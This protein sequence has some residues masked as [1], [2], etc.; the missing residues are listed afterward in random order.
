MLLIDEVSRAALDGSRPADKVIAWAWYDGAL[1]WDEPLS[2]NSWSR[3]DTGDGKQ[4]VQ[5]QFQLTIADPDGSLSPWLFHDPLG[6]GGTILQIIYQ[7]G[8]AESLNIGWFR[9][10][11]NTPEQSHVHYTI[12]E[13]GYVE[14]DSVHAPHERSVMVP[15]GGTVQ[16]TAVDI[17]A[18]VD[19]DKLLTPES[20]KTTTVL[21]EVS[22][23]I[24]DHFP[25]V[26]EDGVVDGPVAKTLVYERERLEA[27][28]D[29]LA[30]VNARYRMGGDGEMR[31]YPID[32]GPVVWRVEPRAGLVKVGRGQSIAGLYNMWVVT[33]KED[34]TGR[35][36]S[37]ISTIKSGPLRVDG[38]HGRVPN[39]FESEQITSVAAAQKYA[40]TLRDRQNQTY[41]VE[42]SVDTIPRPELQA[43]DRIEVGCPVKDGHVIYIP[44]EVTSIQASGSPVPGPMSLKVSC[45][46]QD[47]FDALARTDWSQYLTREKP[48]LTW[49]RMPATWGTAPALT[50]N[51]LP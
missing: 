39:F 15:A 11:G 20:P 48:P 18:N 45:S 38:P 22:R 36:I 13:Y 7:I 3:S 17:T 21:G 42:L 41:A 50:W 34:G 27:V 32:P 31:V 14:P 16:V 47:I 25:V 8:G 44:G 29:L 23:L 30:S 6:V 2:I 19:R 43:G 51:D 40:E 4:K 37:A 12:P 10:E 46:Y 26:I 33:G 5:R 28:Q 35:P 24:G 9:V 49:D 1:A